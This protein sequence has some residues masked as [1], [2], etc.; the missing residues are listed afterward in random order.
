[1]NKCT[2][3]GAHIAIGVGSAVDGLVVGLVVIR[4]VVFSVVCTLSGL[5]QDWISFGA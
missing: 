3:H 2:S 5:V 4:V 1:V